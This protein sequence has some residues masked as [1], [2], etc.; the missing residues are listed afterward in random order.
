MAEN[1]EPVGEG[2]ATTAAKGRAAHL[3]P[4]SRD[5]DFERHLE[6]A[7]NEAQM[8]AVTAE[9]GPHLVIAGAG[10]GKTRTLVYR[11]AYLVRRGVRPESILLLT[12]TRRASQEML[13][14]ATSLLDERCRRV[15]GGTYHSF[16]NLVLRRYAERLEFH[17]RFT[18]LDRSDAVDL[19]GTLRTEAGLD[20]KD[21][22]FM[23]ART[24]VDLYS[25]RVNTQKPIQE[26]L[27]QQFP[28]FAEDLDD[29]LD[30]E[31]RYRRRK[32]EQ[33]VMD[34]D[35]LLV[36]LR[37][38][39][40]EHADVRKKLA[41]QYRHVL[42]DEYQDTNRLQAHIS[43]LLASVHRN[44]MVVGDDAQSIYSF[45]GAN[46]RNILDFPK[47]FPNCRQTTLEQNYRSTQPILDL[48]NAILESAKE[49]FEKRLFTREEGDTRPR[50]VRTPDDYGQA[51]F[52]CRRVLEL[53]EEGV[54][55]GQMAVLA[56][57]AWH[58]NSLELELQSHNIPFR[59]FGGIRFVEAAHVKDVC[60][61]LKLAI[62][63]FDTLA[64]F[65][66]LQLFEGIGPKTA[67]SITGHVLERGG[68]PKVLVQ[69]K[70][71]VKKYGKSLQ[72]LAATLE[73]AGD[74][75]KS[76]A[77]R[78]EAVLESYLPWMER[79]YDDAVVRARDL[80]ALSV[81]AERYDEVEPF[82][83]DLAIDPPDFSRGRPMDDD[84]DEF[85]T[86]STVHSAKGLEWHSVF[87]LQMNAGRF[88][89]YQS[90]RDEESYEEE[91]RL[92]YVAVT[93]ARRN[94]FLIKPEEVAT[95]AYS[96]E[97][98]ELSP[99]LADLRG[100]YDLVDE[101]TYAPGQDATQPSPALEAD[102]SDQLQRIDDYFSDPG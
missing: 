71:A 58:T 99:L 62:N 67:R 48:G 44:L 64:W 24:L 82:L 54:P 3:V 69:P 8:R 34:Y 46:Y 75:K 92:L 95:R 28:Q 88:P 18:I 49:R 72:A 86:V 81:I 89:A 11:V 85:L 27:E 6:G 41:G 15:A 23:Q 97:V 10:S 51:E 5:Q 13:R 56:R 53:R 93:R 52:V 91:R 78:L 42:V 19:L 60:A 57:A 94:L 29:I 9:D 80:E 40:K 45:R 83:T 36:Y 63:P 90:L 25:R 98:G 21:R 84:E 37:D 73:Q 22:R 7:L 74:G 59:K 38:L 50:L 61:L 20:R 31:G 39:L 32:K 76:L 16:A 1:G 100:L 26:L 30:L 12:F 43:A 55:L 17:E 102:D 79:N 4:D 35:D 70:L 66:V 87:V 65:R 47:I 14:R 96:Y 101:E 68:D 2:R 77:G 33:N